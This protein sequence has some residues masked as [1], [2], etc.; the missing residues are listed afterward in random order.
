MDNPILSLLLILVLVICG[1]IFVNVVAN[2][3]TSV[4]AITATPEFC[5]LHKWEYHNLNPV[6]PEDGIYMKCSV[7]HFRAGSHRTKNGDY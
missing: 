6:N 2:I 4:S 3:F 1:V 5:K 7:C